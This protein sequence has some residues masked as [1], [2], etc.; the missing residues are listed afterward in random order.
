MTVGRGKMKVGIITIIGYDNYGNRL[1]NYAVK[2]ILNDLGLDA[3]TLDIRYKSEKYLE[4]NSLWKSYLKK[5]LPMPI[6][7]VIK[8]VRL[9]GGIHLMIKWHRFRKCSQKWTPVKQIV[10]KSFKEIKK[11]SKLKEYDYFVT[12]SDQVWNP[13]LYGLPEYFLEFAEPQ[14]RIGFIASMAVEEIPDDKKLYYKNV[15]S[16]MKYIS[17][18]EKN[19]V[20]LIEQLIGK[21]ADCFLDPTL[22]LDRA[23][24]EQVM[25]RPEKLPDAYIVSFFLGE[26]PSDLIEEYADTKQLPLVRLSNLKY[27]D[28]YYI[29]PAEFIYVIGH[30][31]YVLTDSFHGTAFS[32][33]FG[34]QFYVFNRVQ[35][36]MHDMFARIETLLARYNLLGQIRKRNESI[37]DTTVSRKCFAEIEEDM[38]K[39]RTRF[40]QIMN[41]VFDL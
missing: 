37:F 23:E 12:G 16:Q 29:D 6:V 14:K 7:C 39:E 15:L 1:Q 17:V 3:D 18:R 11:N 36:G 13:Q 32:I 22:L 40:D 9:T 19:S 35:K 20:V 26:E 25:R 5:I 31:E 27:R 10:G 34:R 38:E 4:A 21:K 33:K 41:R 2:R 28:Y 30:A 24:W 8:D